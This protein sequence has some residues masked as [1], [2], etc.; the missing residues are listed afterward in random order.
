MRKPLK[1][2][3]RE[4]HLWTGGKKSNFFQAVTDLTLLTLGRF[5]TDKVRVAPA[6]PPPLFQRS[7]QVWHTVQGWVLKAVAP[8]TPGCQTMIRLEIMQRILCGSY[9]CAT[10]WPPTSR[11]TFPLQTY[12]LGS[13]EWIK[14]L[15]GNK[16]LV[17]QV[18]VCA[19]GLTCAGGSSIR[20]YFT[21]LW[22]RHHSES[23][24]GGCADRTKAL[25]LLLVAHM[26]VWTCVC[27]C[28]CLQHWRG[29]KLCYCCESREEWHVRWKQRGLGFMKS[30]NHRDSTTFCLSPFSLCHRKF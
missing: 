22:L 25:T 12:I 1:G 15:F 16:L 24:R 6:G 30:I 20:F 8:P 19:R 3:Q 11:G 10:G 9:L 26:R 29:P 17:W 23:C 28:T 21:V 7:R 13:V 14:T 18:C 2:T 5:D 27:V 4:K